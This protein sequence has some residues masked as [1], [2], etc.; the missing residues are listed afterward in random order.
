MTWMPTDWARRVHASEPKAPGSETRPGSHV[1]AFVLRVAFLVCLVAIT[2]RVSLPQN[3]TL[4]TIYDT[5]GDLIRLVLGLAVCAWI[6]VQLFHAP[7]PKDAH[8]RETW[9]Y[10]GLAAV[11]F[12][13]LC[14]FAT[15]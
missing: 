15:W 10:F 11:P 12:A 6:A 5:P 14:L 8:G 9:L 4:W 1:A 13:L 3:E 7:M 2:A